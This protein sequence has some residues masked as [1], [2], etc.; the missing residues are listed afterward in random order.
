[1]SVFI[2][3]NSKEFRLEVRGTL[4]AAVGAELTLIYQTARSSIREVPAILDLRNVESIDD[5]GQASVDHLVQQGMAC[6]FAEPEA[7]MPCWRTALCCAW[8]SLWQGSVP[9]MLPSPCRA[10]SRSR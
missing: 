1:M 10:R 5:D 3:D 6:K 7:E 4:N 8:T 2:H 9:A